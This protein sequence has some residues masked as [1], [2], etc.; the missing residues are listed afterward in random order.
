MR[1][2]VVRV[3]PELGAY[4]QPKCGEKRTG[5]CDETMKDWE[6]CPMGKVRP[7]KEQIFEL[8]RRHKAGAIEPVTEADL[9]RVEDAGNEP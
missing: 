3:A 7:H 2:E 1:R 8:F 5:Y 9:R 6:L 4:I